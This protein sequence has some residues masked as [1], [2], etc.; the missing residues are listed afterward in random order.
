M[1]TSSDS[2]ADP[3]SATATESTSTRHGRAEPA[4]GGTASTA[5]ANST[6]APSGAG[7]GSGPL[8]GKIE[9]SGWTQQ[10]VRLLFDVLQIVALFAAAYA[11]YDS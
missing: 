1:P 8:V 2:T 10:D 4:L 9:R 11:A 6:E 3:W 7:D 5:S